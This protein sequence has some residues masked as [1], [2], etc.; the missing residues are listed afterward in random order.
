[1]MLISYEEQVYLLYY[2]L[3][4]N[5]INF[6]PTKENIADQLQVEFD[7]DDAKVVDEIFELFKEGNA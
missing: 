1:M 7:V 4:T 6:K 5:L 3:R 2:W